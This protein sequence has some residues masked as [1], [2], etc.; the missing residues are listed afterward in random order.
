MADEVDS[1]EPEKR[2][3]I[4]EIEKLRAENEALKA[5][6]GKNTGKKKGRGRAF[7]VW[8]LI[9]LACIFSI[10]GTLSAWVR[11]TTLDTNAFVNTVAP[12]I[13]DDAVAKAISDV[14]VAQL[15][16]TYDV[17]GRIKQGLE[18]LSRV[19]KQAV[20]KGTDLPDIDISFI[21]G[22]MSS[23]IEGFAK[24]AA[25]KILQSGVF[26][27][28]W[29]KTLR[30]S[31][32]AMVNIISGKKNAVVTSKGDTV[33]LNLGELLGGVK[34]QLADAGLGFL[35]NVQVP[36][37]FGQIELFTSKQLGV[38]KSWVHLLEM[39][40]WVL[41]LIALILFI[42]AVVLARDRRKALLRSGLGL[43]VA[44]LVVLIVLKVAHG[45]LLGQVKQAEQLAA[46]NVVWGTVLAG[47]KQAVW[48]L[49]VLGLV[50]SIGSAVAGPSR[51]AAWL[52]E[53]VTDFFK[54]WRER[55]EAGA[56]A[57]SPF[58]AFIN[59]HAWWFRAGG[60]AVAVLVLVLIPHI[61]ALA[62]ILTVVILGI[63][64]AAVELLR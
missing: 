17:S 9:I 23:G 7:L 2:L 33:V 20:P 30:A 15:F 24:T 22:P 52:R 6:V 41:P 14:A 50:F 43:A 37:D 4:D 1:P 48:G 5:Q 32:Q 58:Y 3:S 25:Q 40:A 59:E 39:L 57:K 18:D 26:F 63:Y 60:F 11:T 36:A 29:E 21:A 51:W 42:L 16:K 10:A 8:L 46:A 62:V 64:L 19:I 54:N 31:H 27:K 55:R 53:H 47:L 45:Q 35:K 44:M 38:A 28:V 12:L 13:K 34:D 61:S 49:L 56:E